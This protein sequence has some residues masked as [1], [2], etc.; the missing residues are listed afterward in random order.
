MCLTGSPGVDELEE[1]NPGGV[2]VSMCGEFA[3]GS[4]RELEDSKR[5]ALAGGSNRAELSN[6]EGSKRGGEEEPVLGDDVRIDSRD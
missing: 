2:P 6:R 1:P 4:K 3:G 5:D